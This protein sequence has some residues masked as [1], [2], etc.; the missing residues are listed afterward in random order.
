[1]TQDWL[2]T[3]VQHL[4]VQARGFPDSALKPEGQA[5][6][7]QNGQVGD[8][9]RSGSRYAKHRT[10]RAYGSAT[11]RELKQTKRRPGF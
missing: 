5:H 11:V 10:P 6:P 4:A 8:A 2:P 3:D 7:V 9:G 1:M